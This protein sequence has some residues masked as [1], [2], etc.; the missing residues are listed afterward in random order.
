MSFHGLI[1]HSRLLLTY[2]LFTERS[3]WFELSLLDNTDIKFKNP[4]VLKPSCITWKTS[5]VQGLMFCQIL[6]SC[7]Y[8]LGRALCM[9]D[10]PLQS[11][12]LYKVTQRKTCPCREWGFK[13]LSPC[14]SGRVFQTVISMLE[15][16]KTVHAS[17][18]VATVISNILECMKLHFMANPENCLK[19]N[20][21][22]M[23][24]H[25][26]HFIRALF[27]CRSVSFIFGTKYGF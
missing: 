22:W 25:S 19:H 15:W 23:V 2:R 4:N 16:Q 9:E 3:R 5:M 13:Q 8:T 17:D 6:G 10:W 18:C 26:F 14:W 27:F 7:L 1:E 24:C 21:I 12:Y 20:W 11:L